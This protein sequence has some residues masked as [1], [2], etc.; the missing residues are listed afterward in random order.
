MNN[1][2]SHTLDSF[3][4]RRRLL[5]PMSLLRIFSN[6][7]PHIQTELGAAED[8]HDAGNVME[9]RMV[10]GHEEYAGRNEH[11]RVYCGQR[12]TNYPHMTVRNDA[13]T[14]NHALLITEY[15]VVSTFLSVVY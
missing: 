12:C 14:V 5:K 9:P 4:L 7:P 15:Q 6:T 2:E 3:L 10:G 13:T 8:D 11:D 1:V